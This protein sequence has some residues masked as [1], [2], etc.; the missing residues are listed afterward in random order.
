MS[1]IFSEL[2]RRNVFRVA[3]AY[4]VI[5]WLLLQIAD[6]L[7]PALHLPDWIV[8]AITLVLL[9]GF[10]P[11]LLF[12][13]AYE[14][15]PDGLKKDSE[16]DKSKSDTSQTAKKLDYI[17]IAM[18]IFGVGFLLVERFMLEPTVTIPIT[19]SSLIEPPP[20]NSEQASKTSAKPNIDSRS[21][22]VLPFLNLSSEK[23]QEYFSDGLADTLLHQLAQ[24]PDLRVAARTSSFKFKGRNEDI[25]EIARQLGVATILEGSVQRQDNRVRITAQ[26]IDGESGSHLWS[27]VFDDTLDDVFRVHDEI[28]KSVAQALQVSLSGEVIDHSI[29][30][31]TSNIA[32][33]EAYLKG[34]E[35]NG[36]GTPEDSN[37][38]IAQLELAIKLDPDYA[39]AWVALSHAYIT[40]ASIGIAT[41]E[42]TLAPRLAAAERAVALAPNLPEAHLAYASVLDYDGRDPEKSKASIERAVELGPNNAAALESLA[43]LRSNEGFIQDALLLVERAVLLNPLDQ[44]LRMSLAFYKLEVGLVDEAKELGRKIVADAPN[45]LNLLTNYAW[46]LEDSGE[47]VQAARVY[48]QALQS[49]P[50]LLRALFQL[51]WI[52][53]FA[54]DMEQA[55]SYLRR[56]EAAS[57]NRTL[58]DRSIRCLLTGELKCQLDFGHRYLQLQRDSNSSV[59]D[60]WEGFLRVYQGDYPQTIALMEPFIEK[61]LALNVQY[62]YRYS[63]FELAVAYDRVGAKDKRD[64]LLNA[65]EEKMQKALKNGLATRLSLTTFMTLAAIR[66]DA[67][68][69]SKYL[70]TA[71]DNQV[72]PP[73]A[74]LT[75]RISY[76]KVRD[77]PEFQ[78]QLERVQEQEAVLKKQL[79]AEN[80]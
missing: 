42:S 21:I 16:V 2:K 36:R 3:A 40:P 9:L 57:P 29:I 24:L 38:A 13:W 23:D 70:A 59:A 68:L 65:M 55:D 61:Q 19:E 14:L 45:N 58:D 5:G 80:L 25:R 69:A 77:T 66:G 15:T 75:H 72:A 43:N 7:T 39:L 76:D 28:S 26:L 1:N 52:H 46:L 33:Y 4:V 12:S 20:A 30:G 34:V 17:T 37:I 56:A 6:T 54:G 60:L 11:A 18:I 50:K 48:H 8:S 64:R 47:K 67:K 78:V 44:N 10:I 35:A 73:F 51:E 63:L 41:W 62:Y 79:A 74:H 53:T 22:A 27:K 31:G 32:A 71:I 49:N